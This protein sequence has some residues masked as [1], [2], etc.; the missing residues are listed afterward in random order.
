[1]LFNEETFS[2]L[3]TPKERAA[4]LL[5]CDKDVNTIAVMK[6][7]V[8]VDVKEKVVVLT[9]GEDAIVI[10]GMDYPEGLSRKEMIEFANDKLRE[11]ANS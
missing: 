1:M 11:K 6:D 9:D 5:G 10:N 3:E 7:L 8:P 4:Y 2:T